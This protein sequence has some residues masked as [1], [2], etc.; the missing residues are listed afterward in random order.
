MHKK[1]PGVPFSEED[2]QKGFAAIDTT[3]DGKVNIDDIR[4]ITMNKVKKENLF[5][6]H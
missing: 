6:E 1:F 5:F 3:K 4:D 2:F